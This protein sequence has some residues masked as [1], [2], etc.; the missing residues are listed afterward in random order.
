VVATPSLGHLAR[1]NGAL[2]VAAQDKAMARWQ[3]TNAFN[4]PASHPAAGLM[5]VR[6]I[7][8]IEVPWPVHCLGA[9]SHWRCLWAVV[10]VRSGLGQ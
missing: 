10:L 1:T 2:V 6:E 7:R 4:I 9:V 8:A 3:A 5:P